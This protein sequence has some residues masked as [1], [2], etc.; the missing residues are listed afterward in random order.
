MGRG[1]P[2]RRENVLN[3]E[4]ERGTKGHDWWGNVLNE[5]W[6]WGAEALTAAKMS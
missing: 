5:E 2:D 1:G 3:E 6:E 4:W